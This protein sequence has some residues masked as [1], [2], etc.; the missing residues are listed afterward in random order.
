MKIKTNSL[1]PGEPKD[2]DGCTLFSIYRAFAT[3]E[4]TA[5]LRLRYAEGIGWVEM[6]QLLF[7]HLDAEL[8]GPRAQY[9]QLL[10]NPAR[11]E[12]ILAAGAARARKLT[13]PFLAEIRDAIGIRSLAGLK[14]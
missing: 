6:K 8:A 2:P 7:E 11:I 13:R 4:Q 12:E 14:A 9:E 3:P 1:E 5:A 10:A